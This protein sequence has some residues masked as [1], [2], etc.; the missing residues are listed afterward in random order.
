M[1]LRVLAVN[2]PVRHCP[3]FYP[4]HRTCIFTR[5]CFF[6]KIANMGMKFFYSSGYEGSIHPFANVRC[7][8]REFTTNKKSRSSLSPVPYY[9]RYNSQS[10]IRSCFF[11]FS[12]FSFFSIRRRASMKKTTNAKYIYAF[13]HYYTFIS[14][15]NY[16]RQL[17]LVYK[18]KY[19]TLW[20][21][22]DFPPQGFYS[23]FNF[24]FDTVF[25]FI[26]YSVISFFYSPRYI[27]DRFEI[28]KQ[29]LMLVPSR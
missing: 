22:W 6:I 5:A 1:A 29:R 14:K 9:L 7:S 15:L 21:I 17:I 16:T 20:F 10:W 25:I 12:F 3:Y 19:V 28:C 2:P 11:A 8:A 4:R 13:K 27:I 23:I 26:I 18:L 24:S